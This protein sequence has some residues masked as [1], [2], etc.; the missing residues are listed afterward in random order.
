MLAYLPA[1]V[2]TLSD[3]VL[4]V[5]QASLASGGQASASAGQLTKK[6]IRASIPAFGILISTYVNVSCTVKETPVYLV[7]RF[8]FV[9]SGS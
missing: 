9:F 3:P 4:P 6:K 1:A 5:T 8:F 2:I 7:K